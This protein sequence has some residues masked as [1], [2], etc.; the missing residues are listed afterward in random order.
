[1]DPTQTLLGLQPAP[2]SPKPV[3]VRHHTTKKKDVEYKYITMY[4][5]LVFQIM[6][7][8]EM[9]HEWTYGNTM[10]PVFK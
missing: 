10:F 8:F 1:M 2:R 5:Y 7:I 4:Q 9:N 3:F 6:K